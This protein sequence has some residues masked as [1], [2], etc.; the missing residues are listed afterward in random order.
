L[1]AL[2]AEEGMVLVAEGLTE[3]GEPILMVQEF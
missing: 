1:P 3:N 2:Q